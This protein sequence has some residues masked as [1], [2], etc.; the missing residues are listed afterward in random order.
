M[1]VKFGRLLV[2]EETNSQYC[3][4]MKRQIPAS[5]ECRRYGHEIRFRV[6]QTGGKEK[7]RVN[8]MHQRGTPA[9]SFDRASRGK[10]GQ[11]GSAGQGGKM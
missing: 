7:E 1:R 5:P 10:T 8:S 4:Y 9:F 2:P 6:K 11:R 3:I